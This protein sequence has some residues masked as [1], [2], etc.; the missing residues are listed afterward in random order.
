MKPVQGSTIAHLVHLAIITPMPLFEI[1][2]GRNKFACA[3][4]DQSHGSLRHFEIE[5]EWPG[6]IE[7]EGFWAGE[8]GQEEDVSGCTECFVRDQ[9]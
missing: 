1:G 3:I 2:R 4:G 9:L 7:V 8:N 6:Q 5:V